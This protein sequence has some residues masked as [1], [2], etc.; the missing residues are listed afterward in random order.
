MEPG[1]EVV[2]TGLVFAGYGED[3]QRGKVLQKTSGAFFEGGARDVHGDVAQAC[4]TAQQCGDE[5]SCLDSTA[6]AEFYQ[7]DCF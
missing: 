7:R 3:I 1:F 2:E 5:E 6:A 4:L